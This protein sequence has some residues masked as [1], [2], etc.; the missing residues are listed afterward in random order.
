MYQI[1]LFIAIFMD[2]I[3]III[4]KTFEQANYAEKKKPA[5]K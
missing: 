3:I 2:I 5:K 1:I 4:A